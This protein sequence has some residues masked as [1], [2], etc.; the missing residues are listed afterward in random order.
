MHAYHCT[1]D[2]RAHRGCDTARVERTRKLCQRRYNVSVHECEATFMDRRNTAAQRERALRV[3]HSARPRVETLDAFS[4]TDA[5][6]TATADGRHYPQLLA[7]INSK[8]LQMMLAMSN[9][10]SQA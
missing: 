2:R 1:D 5:Q 3:L 4:L 9:S 7:R 6:C 8:W 10:P